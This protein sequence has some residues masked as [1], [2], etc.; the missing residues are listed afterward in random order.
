M[1]TPC[2]FWQP[3]SAVSCGLSEGKH[4]LTKRPLR[5]V[6]PSSPPQ[7][8]QKQAC[9]PQPFQLARPGHA[10]HQFCPL[11][12]QRVEGCPPSLH[13]SEWGAYQGRTY[14]FPCGHRWSPVSSL[15]ESFRLSMI[16]HRRKGILTMPL[17][18]VLPFYSGD[19][20]SDSAGHAQPQL[21]KLGLYG[22][23][24]FQPVFKKS[25]TRCDVPG[26]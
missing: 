14:G 22:A 20:Q 11:V 18:P 1:G 4:C 23:Q 21:I 6:L 13:G 7:R 8:K 2:F 16:S 12:S 9:R 26:Y 10:Q 19:I 15:N 24:D 17:S 5:P 3:R 25:D